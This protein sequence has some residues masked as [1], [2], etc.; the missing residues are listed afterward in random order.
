[1]QR[2]QHNRICILRSGSRP[3]CGDSRKALRLRTDAFTLA[4]S[5]IPSQ[6]LQAVRPPSDRAAAVAAIAVA[7]STAA[8]NQD[9]FRS[10]V[11]RLFPYFQHSSISWSPRSGSLTAPCKA[12]IPIAVKRSKKPSHCVLGI[13]KDCKLQRYSFPRFYSRPC[14]ICAPLIPL[15]G[16]RYLRRRFQLSRP[17]LEAQPSLHKNCAGERSPAQ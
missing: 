11:S 14:R 1:M 10:L 4:L 2:G 12:P 6:G 15:L 17:S 16:N 5:D 8:A 7:G 13:P 3:S 9:G